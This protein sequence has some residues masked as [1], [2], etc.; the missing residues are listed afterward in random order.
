MTSA[1]GRQRKELTVRTVLLSCALVSI[2]ATVGIVVVLSVEAVSFFEEVPIADF[3]FGTE[4]TPLLEPAP[5]IP[6]EDMKSVAVERGD[7]LE[8]Q[9]ANP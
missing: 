7:I 3:L 2:A 4:W 8:D 9:G 6:F 5:E 1:E